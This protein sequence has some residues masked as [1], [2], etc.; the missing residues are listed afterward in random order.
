[1]KKSKIHQN[2]NDF[3]KDCN[4]TNE[5]THKLESFLIEYVKITRKY[6]YEI[7][8]GLDILKYVILS[9]YF[10]YDRYLLNGLCHVGYLRYM[11]IEFRIFLDVEMDSQMIVCEEDILIS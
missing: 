1:M 10:V 2:W 9:N 4:W 8:C 11:G 7:I 5:I 6:D 3:E